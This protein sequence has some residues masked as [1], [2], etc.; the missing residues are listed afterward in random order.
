M[1]IIKGKIQPQ[2]TNLSPLNIIGGMG[3]VLTIRG[4]GFGDSRGT[5]FVSFKQNDPD[6]YMDEQAGTALNYCNWSDKQIEVEMPSAYSGT[7]HM[8][9]DGTKCISPEILNVKA[10]F[11]TISTNPLDYFH[12]INKNGRG[13][14]TWYIHREYWE[15]SDAR[16][17][18]EEVFEEFRCKTGVNFVLANHPTDEIPAC[19]PHINLIGPDLTIPVGGFH[20]LCWYTSPAFSHSVSMNIG[21]SSSEVWYY[22]KGDLQNGSAK[23]RYVLMHELGHAAGLGHVNELGQTMYPSV[24]LQPSNSWFQ[25]D[26]LTNEEVTAISHFVKLSQNFAFRGPGIT[27]LLPITDCKSIYE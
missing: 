20:Y 8:N 19:N 4:T 27:P 15:N 5:N 17:A 7:I 10:N 16:T 12:L 6:I 11:N 13:G 22:G 23:F 3:Q 21:M 24:T 1:C 18:I 2:I 14:Y 9:I 25:R 26:S